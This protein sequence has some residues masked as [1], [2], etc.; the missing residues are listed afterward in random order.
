[1]KLAVT[2]FFANQDKTL[3]T[4]QIIDGAETLVTLKTVELP[5]LNNEIGKSCIPEG[6]YTARVHQSPK[7]GWSLWLHNVRGRSQILVHAANYVRQLKGCIAP[8]LF[9]KDIDKDGI[10][11]V[12]NSK[13]AMDILKIYLNNGNYEITVKVDEG[14]PTMLF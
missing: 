13:D 2:R 12:T 1:M 9:H 6:T 3:G 11:D 10:I 7:F 5:W 4:L 14:V 8:G